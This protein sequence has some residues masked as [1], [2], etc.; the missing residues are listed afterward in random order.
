MRNINKNKITKLLM[1]VLIT[2]LCGCNSSNYDKIIQYKVSNNAYGT[3]FYLSKNNKDYLVTAKHLFDEEAYKWLADVYYRNSEITGGY[4]ISS[5]KVEENVEFKDI[6]ERP[7][8]I[9]GYYEGELQIRN[10]Y[11]VSRYKNESIDLIFTTAKVERGMSGSPCFDKDDNVIGVLSIIIEG[12][13]II[14]SAVV[15]IEYIEGE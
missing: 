8:K 1:M 14:K 5:L 3:A 9:I 7:I 10:G 2:S 12:S 13:N 4:N 11:I 15:P 6:K